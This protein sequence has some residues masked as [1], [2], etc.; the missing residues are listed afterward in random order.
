MVWKGVIIE[1]SLE[2]A[3]LLDMVTEVGY[4]ESLLEGEDEK[5][6]MHF[7]QFEIS[8]DKKDGFISNAK[9]MIKQGWYIHICRD[10]KMI[11]VFKGKTFEFTED[12]KDKIKAAKDY[13]ISLGILPEQLE[14]ESLI[15]NPF[16]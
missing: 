9:N 13:G 7:H 1:E 8:D 15:R 12:E 3:S 4:L 14:I 5:G 16:D 10:E 11:I 2:D 6:T